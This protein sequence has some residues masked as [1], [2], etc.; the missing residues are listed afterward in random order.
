MKINNKSIIDLLEA[1]GA[2][3]LT[4]KNVDGKLSLI[5]NGLTKNVDTDHQPDDN[6]DF[7]SYMKFAQEGFNENP[8]GSE[9]LDLLH[10]CVGISEEAGET[11]GHIKK[12]VFH[13]LPLDKPKIVLEF[14][15]MLWYQA[16][17]LKLLDITLSDV[18]ESNQIKLKS[19]YPNGR[20]KNFLLNNRDHDLETKLTADNLEKKNKH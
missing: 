10:C 7:S 4:I 13:D 16:N 17:L 14:G 19:R 12:H 20:N 5:V 15:D 6:V 8:T 2:T 1:E 3:E 11:L 9:Y 18:L